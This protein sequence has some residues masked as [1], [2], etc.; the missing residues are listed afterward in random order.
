[1]E[2]KTVILLIDDD[3][4]FLDVNKMIIEGWGYDVRTAIGGKCGIEEFKKARPDLI[5]VDYLMPDMDGV[6][7]IREIRVIDLAVPVVMFSG[8]PS[9][10]TIDGIKELQL[11][12]LVP[13]D[14]AFS[15]GMAALKMIMAGIT[16]RSGS[17][18]SNS[19]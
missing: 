11:T 4:D 9:D 10:V 18:G 17:E 14:S 2:N 3:P 13:K 8:F 1:M 7:T 12:A 19:D 5:I 16:K 15:T 6:A